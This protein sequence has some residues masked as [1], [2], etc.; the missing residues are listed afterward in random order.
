MKTILKKY[1]PLHW[2]LILMHYQSIFHQESQLFRKSNMYFVVY[3]ECVI[4]NTCAKT[5]WFF[6][7]LEE[8]S[9]VEQTKY[10]LWYSWTFPLHYLYIFCH[11][12]SENK[13]KNY[14]KKC[15]RNIQ[16]AIV[17]ALWYE[18]SSSHDNVKKDELDILP[19]VAIIIHY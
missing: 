6:A 19:V 1:I 12:K 11:P 10:I 9:N 2:R 7:I 4:F 14:L 15:V 3:F 8:N 17:F 5:S 13:K 18:I 16:K